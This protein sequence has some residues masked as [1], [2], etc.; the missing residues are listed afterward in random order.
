[1]HAQYQKQLVNNHY[2]VDADADTSCKIY[3]IGMGI[4]Q[5]SGSER[6][7]ARLALNPGTYITGNNDEANAME[8]AWNSY[9]RGQNP[10]MRTQRTQI[11]GEHRVQQLHLPSSKQRRHLHHRI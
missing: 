7:I 8:T 10:T 2:G 1:M 3:T 11:L 4:E 6:N 9:L 5:L